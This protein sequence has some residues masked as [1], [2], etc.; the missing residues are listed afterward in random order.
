MK[1]YARTRKKIRFRIIMNIILIKNFHALRRKGNT[2]LSSHFD[3]IKRKLKKIIIRIIFFKINQDKKSLR[4]KKQ[5]L[6]EF[7][8][9]KT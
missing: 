5:K 6:I 2:I 9:L 3:N 8:I 1:K 7:K 4:K